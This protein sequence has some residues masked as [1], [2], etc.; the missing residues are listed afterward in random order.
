MN[1]PNCNSDKLTFQNDYL[2]EYVSH[3]NDLSFADLPCI[4]RECKHEFEVT[5]ILKELK[6]NELSTFQR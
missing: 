2:I 1:C 4:C 5:F 3:A 6:T